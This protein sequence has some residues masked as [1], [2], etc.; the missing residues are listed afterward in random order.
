[1]AG[2]D[3]LRRVRRRPRRRRRAHGP[4]P[5]GRRRRPEP[6]VRRR[7]AGRARTPSTWASRPSASTTASRTSPRSAPTASACA[8]SRRSPAAYDAGKIQPDLI[9]VAIKDATAAGASPPRTRALRPETTMEGLAGA[10]DP[11]P[12][13]RPGHGRQRRRRSPTARRCRLLAGGGAVKELGLTPKMR[14]VS[15]RLRR[16]RARDHGHRPDPVAPRR[17]CARPA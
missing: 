16:R 17:R 3:R 1:M 13:A 12:P 10:E 6:A 9:P 8:A 14:L 2:V 15:L 7:E 5:D 11:V 4:P